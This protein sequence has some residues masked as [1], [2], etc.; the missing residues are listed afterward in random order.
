MRY[1]IAILTL[2]WALLPA[3]AQDKYGA[4][5]IYPVYET[6]GQWVIFDKSP[7]KLKPGQS[8]PLGSGSRFLLVGSKGAELFSVARTSA[9]YGGACRKNLPRK[10]RAAILKGPREAVG[11]P[12]IGIR[13]PGN[14]SLK[15]SR[16]K[17]LNL[18]NEVGEDTYSRLAEALKSATIADAKAGGFRFTP[19]DERSP[20]YLQDLEPEQIQLKIDFGSRLAVRGLKDAFVLVDGALVSA[21]S[22]RCLRL[23]D[24]DRLLGQC[25]EM[26]HALMAETGLL[27]FVAYDPGGQGDPYLLAYTPQTPMWGDERWGFVIRSDGP[28][29]FLFDAMDPRCREGF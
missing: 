8:P 21:T 1:G 27:R 2:F 25:V 24:G 23:A 13:V 4:K 12:I 3:K 17:Y 9:T 10:L 20:G 7:Q 18:D 19:D 6:A 28:R 11:T 29:L 15:G 5:G 16:A 22:R 26:P 14:F